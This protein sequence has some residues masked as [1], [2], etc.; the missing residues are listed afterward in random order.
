MRLAGLLPWKA[1]CP[2]TISYRTTPKVNTSL[3]A[4]ASLP[5]NCSGAI[6]C[7]VPMMVPRPVSGVDS[8][9]VAVMAAML[10]VTA[11]RN[12]ATPKSSS[13]AP[14]LVSMMLLGFRSRC[15]TPARCALSSASAI[16]MAHLSASPDVRGPRCRRSASVCPSRCSITR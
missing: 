4:S 12:F 14:L 13:F 5:S 3:R 15:T 16:S 10:P 2:V 8:V 7:G 9:T 1:F 6:Y 11:G